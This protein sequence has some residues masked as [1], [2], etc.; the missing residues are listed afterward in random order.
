MSLI[1]KNQLSMVLQTIKKLLSL[2][3]DKV[4]LD[5][6][7]NKADLS[8]K[9]D[10]VDLITKIDRSEIEDPIKLSIE[11]GLVVPIV[12]DANEIYTSEDGNL[13]TF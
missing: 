13:Y 6:K 1:T 3:A 2:K 8:D 11:M 5:L 7:A 12:S 9:A 4:D 10:K